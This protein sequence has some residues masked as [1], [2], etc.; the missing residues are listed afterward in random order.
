MILFFAVTIFSSKNVFA[1][2]LEDANR[3]YKTGNYEQAVLDYKELSKEHSNQADIFYNLGNSY[4]RIGERS[5]AIL[6]YEK[7]LTLKPRDKDILHNLSYVRELLE[8]RVEDK[9]NWYVKICQKLL[10]ALTNKEA[11]FLAFFICFLFLLSACTHLF[12]R[13]FVFWNWY[14]KMLF[15]LGVVVLVV[16]GAKYVTSDHISDGI[17]ISD[18]IPVRYGPSTHDQIAFR[19]GSGLKVFILE[20]RKEW[21]RILLVNGESGWVKNS[22]IGE[23]RI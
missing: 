1:L 23:V 19:L 17:V 2:S 13:K 20:K 5:K 8:Y 16:A 21:S 15:L 12:F 7:A 11:Y 4:F 14:N 9:R 6:S 3:N 10:G 22:E 18:K